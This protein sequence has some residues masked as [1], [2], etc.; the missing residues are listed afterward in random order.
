M[1]T[2]DS[3]PQARLARLEDIEEIRRL[4][5]RYKLALDGKDTAAYAALFAED[6]V[7][8]CT[9]E[10]VAQGP[11]AIKQLVDDMGGNLLTET[12]GTDSHVIADHR[13]QT[14]GDRARGTLTW[15]YFTIADD[16]GPRLTKIGHYND[17]YVREGGQWKFARREAPTDIPVV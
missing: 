15:M 9:P 10:L 16:G 3:S 6:G 11:A 13:I 14:D 2:A 8:W 17:E 5:V 1:T 12:V 4:V 7:L